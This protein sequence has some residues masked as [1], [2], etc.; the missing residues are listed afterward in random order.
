MIFWPNIFLKNIPANN[1][2]STIILT[3]CINAQKGISKIVL[4]RKRVNKGVKT[5]AKK[6]EAVVKETE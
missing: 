1:G 5:G 4:A 3:L 6:V 2:K